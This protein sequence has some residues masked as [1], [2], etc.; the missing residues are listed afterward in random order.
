MGDVKPEV[1]NKPLKAKSQSS[2]KLIINSHSKNSVMF[3]IALHYNNNNKDS[4][5]GFR[6]K[7]CSLKLS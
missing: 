2:F 3:A 6:F 4:K 5:S 1:I 7:I